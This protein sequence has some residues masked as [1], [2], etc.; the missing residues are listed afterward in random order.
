MIKNNNFIYLI[1]ISF[2]PLFVFFFNQY[3]EILANSDGQHYLDIALMQYQV[4]EELGFI[5]GLES[6]YN[7]RSVGLRP[8][9]YP[10]YITIFMV[11]TNGDL[12]LT[13]S[14]VMSS[15]AFL[16]TIYL[17]RI[18][19]WSGCSK[20]ISAFGS[21]LIVI[22]PG[23]SYYHYNMFSETAHIT[24]FFIF[25]YYILESDHLKNKSSVYKAGFFAAIMLCIR[26][27]LIFI[28]PLGLSFYAYNYFKINKN[29][30][31][32]IKQIVLVL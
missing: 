15:I 17:Y 12:F 8:L 14:L 13:T 28:V 11:L 27:E 31:L 6:M 29:F 3:N 9:I 16:W 30:L 18:L 23:F 1:L 21:V 24:A 32:E 2:A 26:P 20:T 19:L 25:L 10:V 5:A 4:F 7:L 22:W